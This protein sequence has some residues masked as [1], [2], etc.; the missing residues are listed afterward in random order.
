VVSEANPSKGRCA[1]SPAL[2]SRGRATVRTLGMLIAVSS[3]SSLL[4]SACG[5][6]PTSDAWKVFPSSRGAREHAQV[7]DSLL[8][9][10]VPCSNRGSCYAEQDDVFCLC[11]PGFHAVGLQCVPQQEPEASTAEFRAASRASIVSI[12][13]AEEGRGP[14]DVGKDLNTYPYDLGR[15]LGA[16]E[17]WCSEFVSWVYKVAGVPFTGGSEGGWMLSGN[18]GVK[19]W[20]ER[21]SKWMGNGDPGWDAFK[22]APGDFMRLDTSSGGH[23]ALVRE[24]SGSTLYTVEGNVSNRVMLRRYDNY[25]SNSSIDGFGRHVSGSNQ[26]PV[27]Q[28]GADQT[29]LLP[30]LATLEGQVEDDGLP[31]GSLTTTWSQV[32]GPGTVDFSDAGEPA[33]TAAF[34]EPG[35][36]TLRL[37]ANDGALESSDEVK[38]VVQQNQAPVVDAGTEQTVLLSAQTRLQ[39]DVDDDGLPD[40]SLTTTW[41]QVEGPGQA[42][43]AD[44][45][46]VSTTVTFSAAGRYILRLTASDGAAESTSDIEINVREETLEQPTAFVGEPLGCQNTPE[47]GSAAMVFCILLA[48]LLRLRSRLLIPY[49]RLSTRVVCHHGG[50]RGR[51][52]RI[53]SP[54]SPPGQSRR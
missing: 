42:T 45:T 15:Y 34:S 52:H 1:R 7:H 14:D 30:A 22:P 54:T 53:S 6:E 8:C 4:H 37:V 40:G 17:A 38:V 31:D 28:A 11:Q 43:F 12:A 46:A 3:S 39:G 48:A 13:V 29:V 51:P 33:A 2:A 18:T 49:R 16:N 21:D 5:Q 44:D 50:G 23:S 19:Q 26:A 24:V 9:A 27:V 41:S 10:Q 47:G 36:Y 20:F 35:V 25:K 32:E